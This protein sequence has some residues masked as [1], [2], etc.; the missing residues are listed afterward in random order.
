[1]EQEKRSAR[2]AGATRIT[3][4]PRSLE[5]L[6]AAH[7]DA[8]RDIYRA[9]RPADPLLYAGVSRGRLFAVE[10]FGGAYMLTRPLV[11]ALSRRLPV[12]RG[13]VFE[14]GGTSG[15]NLLFAQRAFRFRCELAPSELDGAPTLALRYEDLDNPWPVRGVVDEMREIGDGA[16]GALA[17]GVTLR[18]RGRPLL[19]WGLEPAQ[20]SS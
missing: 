13:K 10:P 17:L 9:A 18:S 2:G 3:F 6:V 14:S 4:Q 11:R 12:W 19:W 15:S 16:A 20:S 8:L 1:M 5:E 7:P